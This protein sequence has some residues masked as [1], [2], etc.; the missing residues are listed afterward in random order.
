MKNT[1]TIDKGKIK[2]ARSKKITKAR[3]QSKTQQSITEGPTQVKKM[4]GGAFN[5][6]FLNACHILGTALRAGNFSAHV[7]WGTQTKRS[8]ANKFK[9]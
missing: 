7:D 8:H 3:V 1:L 5:W 4:K 6:D 2:I 9:N